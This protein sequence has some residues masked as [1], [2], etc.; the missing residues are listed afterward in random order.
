MKHEYLTKTQ[1]AYWTDICDLTLELRRPPTMTQLA[2]R[3]RVSI[4]AAREMCKLLS[5]KGY[6]AYK[7]RYP[8]KPLRWPLTSSWRAV[9]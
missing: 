9:A 4:A 7:S 3:R 1:Y 5:A 8:V 6:V 2:L